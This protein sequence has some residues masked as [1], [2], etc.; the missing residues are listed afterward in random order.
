MQL[1]EGLRKGG[2][3]AARGQQPAEAS[4]SA[5][6]WA[7]G[8]GITLGREHLDGR[9]RSRNLVC[10]GHT[11]LGA[12]EFIFFPAAVSGVTAVSDT[13]H[14]EPQRVRPADSLPWGRL[15][16]SGATGRLFVCFC[17]FCQVL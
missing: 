13:G 17:H 7:G 10:P 4:A 14:W 1:R 3:Q 6:P 5:Q 9:A 15:Q 8:G 2:T 12:R 16:S 11:I